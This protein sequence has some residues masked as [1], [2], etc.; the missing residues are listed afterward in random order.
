MTLSAKHISVSINL[1]PKTVY[2]FTSAPLNMP[3]WASGLSE[4]IK[5]END[6]WIA[7]SPMGKV[8]IKF[9]SPNEWGVIDHDVTLENGKTFHNPLRVLKNGKG[10]EVVFT[11]YRQ[12]EMNEDDF[13]RDANMVQA[14]LIKLKKIL[15]STLE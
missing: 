6:H 8:T 12:P 7:H 15:E 4:S 5:K 14:D 3:K 10:A 11:L 9:S 1:D 2:E 13:N